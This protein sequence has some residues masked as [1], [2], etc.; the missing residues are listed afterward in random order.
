MRATG[1]VV[2]RGNGGY[3]PDIHFINLKGRIDQGRLMNNTVGKSYSI[4]I[5][6]LIATWMIIIYSLFFILI[7]LSGQSERFF[8]WGPVIS[9]SLKASI[10]LGGLFF[11]Y[12]WTL[13]KDRKFGARIIA[14]GSFLFLTFFYSMNWVF[15]LSIGQSMHR[16]SLIM[17]VYVTFSHL[18]FAIYGKEDIP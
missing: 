14:L 3:P 13:L 2:F 1:R 17:Y 10:T 15:A 6:A 18:L 4:W 12:W 5:N 8:Q 11:V 16:L 9:D 7:K